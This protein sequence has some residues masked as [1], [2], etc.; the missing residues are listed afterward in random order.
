MWRVC[1]LCALL[2]SPVPVRSS[3]CDDG[4]SNIHLDMPNESVYSC[5]GAYI[6]PSSQVYPSIVTKYKEEKT[7]PA[8]MDVVINHTSPIPNSGVHRPIEAK[9]GEYIYC[10]PQRWVH[11]L[12]NAGVA[13]LYHPCVDPQLKE[14]LSF[15]ARSCVPRH[16][17]TPL[18][19]L[20][21]E[22]PIALVTWCSTLEMSRMNMT[23][24]RYWLK[25]NI[26]HEHQYETAQ[27]G[28]YQHLLIRPSLISTDRAD[29]CGERDF[30]MLNRFRSHRGRSVWHLL[31]KRRRSEVLPTSVIQDTASSHIST[32]ISFSTLA[33]QHIDKTIRNHSTVSQPAGTSG[34]SSSTTSVV[35]FIHDAHTQSI[36]ASIHS[37]ETKY[38]DKDMSKLPVQKVMPT[39]VNQSIVL[40]DNVTQPV[41]SNVSQDTVKEQP[42][43]HLV[44]PEDHPDASPQKETTINVA[45][46]LET[47][48]QLHHQLT[49]PKLSSTAAEKKQ[50]G[51]Q[52][53]ECNCQRDAVAEL[54]AKAQTRLS[55]GQHKFN[56]GF[57]STPRTQEATWAA[58]SLIFLFS[59]LTFSILYT[60]IY[61]KFRRSQSLY[62]SLGN[63]SEE[64][65][66]V[67]SIIKR[68]LVQGHSRRK[69]W[70]GKKRSPT[71]LY[72]SLSESS[73]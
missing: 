14:V 27:V 32:R 29:L 4:Q 2:V 10:P 11:N 50:S 56:E 44:K 20:S 40:P 47:T 26:P 72:E 7:Y 8:C 18:P 39:P 60:Q 59:L 35:G 15:V 41:G 28:A 3:V 34:L 54:P 66:T 51:E 13:F 57:V 48:E 69:R 53:Q 33:G 16:I 38:N 61:K 65:E 1:A 71:V 63:H 68:R 24:I 70:F 43:Q 37:Q 45:P 5:P 22:R 58:A 62:W 36:K 21:R 12:Q 23:E 31:R 17:I 52:K 64:K 46:R 30:Q 19:S 55:N 25:E 42:S 9:Y 49:D 6:P 67:S 73:D